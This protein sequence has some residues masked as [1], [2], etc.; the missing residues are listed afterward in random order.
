LKSFAKSMHTA[1]P[2][3]PDAPVI[4]TIGLVIGIRWSC[5]IN[6]TER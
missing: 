3:K 2:K 4:I 5:Y 6:L 1:E